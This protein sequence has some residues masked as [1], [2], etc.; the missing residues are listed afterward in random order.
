MRAVEPRFT[1]TITVRYLKGTPLG[2][3][4]AEA[5]ID[6]TEGIKTY[7]RGMLG[8]TDGWTVEAEG[9]FIATGWARSVG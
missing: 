8:T 4:R 3:V 5:F 7:A 6:R 2:P 9:V 1:G